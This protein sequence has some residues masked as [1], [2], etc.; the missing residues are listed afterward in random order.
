[1]VTS[2]FDI[3]NP[4]DI[5]QESE[6]YSNEGVENKIHDIISE[7]SDIQLERLEMK[8]NGYFAILKMDRFEAKIRYTKDSASC[9]IYEYNVH[10]A[11]KNRMYYEVVRNPLPVDTFGVFVSYFRAMVIQDI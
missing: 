8:N 7:N 9:A 2:F 3:V 5:K 11:E 4:E 6:K 10:T 1:M